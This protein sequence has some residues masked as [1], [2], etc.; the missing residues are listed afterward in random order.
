MPEISLVILCYQ[1]GTKIYLFLNA[2]ISHLN[3]ITNHW[4]II[5]VGNY[6]PGTEDS[7]D[8]P[9]VVREIASQNP[10]IRAVVKPK[11]GWMGWDARTGLELCRGKTIGIIDGDE[12]MVAEDISKAYRMLIDNH[13]DLVKPYRSVR[14]DPWIRSLNSYLYNWAYNFLF[15][16]YPV[17]DVNSKPKIFRREAFEKLKLTSNGW[18]L[19]AE[20]MIQARRYRFKM[21]EFSTV[22]YRAFHR[23]SFVRFSAIFE[24]VIHLTRFRFKEFFIKSQAIH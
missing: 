10:K 11:E 13:L 8:T 5:L 4:E 7:D 24:F 3:Q 17:R 23:K 6:L 18:C 21:G 14:Y 19:D 15:P 1:T 2:V 20:M 16:G 12:Q 9:K 22:F